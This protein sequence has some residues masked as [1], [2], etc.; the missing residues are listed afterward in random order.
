MSQTWDCRDTLAQEAVNAMTRK[1]TPGPWQLRTDYPYDDFIR[2][3]TVVE[4]LN[5]D[6]IA[7]VAK[8]KTTPERDVANARLIAA[9]P[10]LLRAARLAERLTHCDNAHLFDGDTVNA[11]RAAIAKAEGE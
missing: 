9:A 2:P 1:H 10:D 3:Y 7:Q 8:R 6:P 4:T 11:L 5:Y